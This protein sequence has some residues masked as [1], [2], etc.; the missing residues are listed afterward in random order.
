MTHCVKNVMHCV[1]TLK[2]SLAKRRA[3]RRKAWGILGL[4]GVVSL[5]WS[6][7]SS[8]FPA[9]GRSSAT[10]ACPVLPIPSHR[11]IDFYTRLLS[12]EERKDTLERSLG[13][14]GLY[15]K[16][17]QDVLCQHRVPRALAYLVLVESHFDAQAESTA[18]AKGLWQL[19]P[20]TARSLGLRVDGMVDERGDP[21]LSTYAAAVHLRYLFERFGSWEMALAAYNAGGGRVA[22]AIREGGSRRFWDLSAQELLPYQ[23]RNYVPKFYAVVRMARDPERFG[24]GPIEYL[25]PQPL[26]GIH[27]DPWMDPKALAVLLGVPV[28]NLRFWN[29]HLG[30][31]FFTRPPSSF[32][33]G[34]R[35]G[36]PD[37]VRVRVPFDRATIWNDLT[38]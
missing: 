11:A 4:V 19:A 27:V 6:A 5:F 36:R 1:M 12:S 30:D 8:S 32:G 37:A 22:E 26:T 29:P 14:S 17:I 9:A 7:S 18:G 20:V 35:F 21:E 24:L 2:M 33:G 28:D 3:E 34:M 25:A 38:S 15:L 10:I 23:T 13:R 31:A 16:F